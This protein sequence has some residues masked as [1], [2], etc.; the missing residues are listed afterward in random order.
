[1]SK[2]NSSA[3]AAEQL[4]QTRLDLLKLPFIKQ[5]YH[6]LADAAAQKGL[7]HVAYLENLIEGEALLK[8]DRCTARR[9]MQARFPV[10]KTLEQFNWSWPTSINRLQVQNLFRLQFLKD[11]ANVILIGTTGLGKTHLSIALGHTACLQGHSVLFTTA[12]DAVNCLIAAA[13]AGTRK[14]ELQRYLKPKILC[15]DELSYLALDK[16]AADLLF[17]IISRRYERGSTII[18]TNLTYKKWTEMLNNDATLTS[19][20]LDRLLH[21]ADTVRITGKSYRTREEIE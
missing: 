10:I 5:S 19:A 1:M 17:Q 3:A 20:L 9:I 4:L 7:A 18:T 21:H 11:N 14:H 16:T 15:L 13:K 6:A 2:N 12:L 8:H